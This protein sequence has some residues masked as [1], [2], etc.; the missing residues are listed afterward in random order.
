MTG[1][2]ELLVK[3]SIVIA[4]GLVLAA[5]LRQQSA[6][7]RHWMLAAALCCAA[8]M[9]VLTPLG[10]AWTLPAMTGVRTDGGV[11]STT[12]FVLPASRDVSPADRE[13]A[14]ATSK[15]GFF[16][17]RILA[18]IWIA[19]TLVSLLALVASLVRLRVVARR[20]R[21]APRH[22]GAGFV[23]GGDVTLLVGDSGAPVMTW[24]WRRPSILLPA[25]AIQWPDERLSAV[26]RH[27][28]AHVARGDW[29]LQLLASI[30]R[31][32]YWFNPLLW[33]LCRRLRQ[34]SEQACDDAVLNSGIRAHAYAKQL[35]YL[36]RAFSGRSL[37]AHALPVARPSGLERR[38]R[39]M[40]NAEV[41]RRNPSVVARSV[42][43]CAVAA[44]AVAI[45]GG[46]AFAQGPF[47]TVSGSLLDPQ[48]AALPAG[49][50]SVTNVATEARNEV[51]SNSDGRFE[52]VGLPPGKYLLS[53]T[54][55]GFARYQAT[56]E[57][58]GEQLDRDIVMRVSRLEENVT[59]TG[60]PTP[61]TRPAPGPRPRPD[62]P[63][64]QAAASP[65]GTPIGG[66][67][68]P[69]LK[70]RHVSPIYPPAAREQGVGGTV[71][72]DAVIG[73]D[74]TVRDVTVT[75]PVNPEL[76]RAAADAVRE[77]QFTE[78]LLN[79]SPIEVTM[80]VSINFRP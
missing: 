31:A 8:A 42:S 66:N 48:R 80:T 12:T 38:V 4:A 20:A 60:E 41:N 63:P 58:N 62:V 69:P 56:L 3:T 54:T 65:T 1:A 9:P 30:V 15:D 32:F 35:L 28:L 61:A 2:L 71:V 17:G 40:L 64:C 21:P 76:D 50:I 39:A 77:W 67:L 53:A 57:L 36:A 55:P 52:L 59:V 73:I 16:P 11:E 45:A 78:T 51:K 44:I 18:T 6:A 26:L 29:S 68:K 43:A 37:P 27:E 46:S 70:V 13:G 25:G 24:G 10:P 74:G 22:L 33:L 7:T 14:A 72:M 79:C 47:A 34:E 49:T 23:L 5:S 19:G 75:S